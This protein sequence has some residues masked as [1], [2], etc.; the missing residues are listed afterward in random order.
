M[1][2]MYSTP[3]DERTPNERA[4]VMSE[5][6]CL[7][8]ISFIRKRTFDQRTPAKRGRGQYFAEHFPVLSLLQADEAATILVC[9]TSE[10]T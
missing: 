2:V 1:K 4:P 7:A 10:V 6:G 8:R 9:Q 3:P 5:H